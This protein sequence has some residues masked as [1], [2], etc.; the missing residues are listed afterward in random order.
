MAFQ[1]GLLEHFDTDMQIEL[2]NN[3][4]KYC[5]TMVSMIPNKSSIPYRVGKQILE[6]NGMWE[7]GRETPEHSMAFQFEEAGIKVVREYTIGTEWALGFLTKRNY[8]RNFFAKMK[9]EGFNLDDL[10]QGY[11]IV[12][13]GEC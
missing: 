5:K 9:K 4:K 12:T 11:L 3:W 2:L 7:Y 6:D 8:I 13:I 10:M 1:S